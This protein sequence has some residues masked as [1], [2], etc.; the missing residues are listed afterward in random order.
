[1]PS[2]GIN[3]LP[4][5]QTYFPASG[6]VDKKMNWNGFAS[7][8]EELSSSPQVD[9][10]IQDDTW[11][12]LAG[13]VG[14]LVLKIV[15]FP[16]GIYEL[17]RY[18]V[19]R[20]IMA[21]LYPAQN[22]L[23][24]YIFGSHVSIDEA[25]SDQERRWSA[26]SLKR[27]G[28]VVRHV[29]LEKNGARYSGMLVGRKD[30][31]QNGKWVLQATG[32]LE[33]IETSAKQFA[34]LYAQCG[35]NTLLINGPGVCRSKGEAD[36]KTMGEAQALGLSFLETAIKA[37]KIVIS[38]RSLGGAA[39][40]QAI[41]Q[42]TFKKDVKYLV[43]RQM[44]FDRASTICSKIVESAVPLLSGFAKFLVQWSGCEMDSVE[45]SKKLSKLGI[46]EVIVQNGNRHVHSFEVPKPEDFASDGV[47]PADASLG[48]ALVSEGVTKN[49]I[50]YC[51]KGLGHMDL[52]PESLHQ[53]MLL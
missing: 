22:S 27:D 50:F 35:F 12:D 16:W 15:L 38:G 6:A 10:S 33:P 42:H 3:F 29:S 11:L 14:L 41:L 48:K 52:A 8:T 40:S 23:V 49:K 20:L 18:G 5:Y 47:I 43:M 7:S 44:T 26:S 39:T 51:L 1:M 28:F 19:Q 17:C 13:R 9:F 45:A 37:K 25:S 24:K 21:P 53:L 32:N 30:K 31:I 36:P 4:I 34:K 46:K 2:E